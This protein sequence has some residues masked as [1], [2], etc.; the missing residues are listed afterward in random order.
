MN[1]KEIISIIESGDSK[2]NFPEFDEHLSRCSSCK[3]F[4][5][6]VEMID[7]PQKQE[8]NVPHNLQNKIMQNVEKYNNKRKMRFLW[9]SVSSVA[10]AL[11]LGIFIGT[12]FSQSDSEQISSDNSVETET[13]YEYLA[14]TTDLMFYDSVISEG[15]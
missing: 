3:A 10:A 8:I 1:C 15:E 14:Q 2:R 11:L 12:M 7:V 4:V 9:T 6:V 13:Q 5:S